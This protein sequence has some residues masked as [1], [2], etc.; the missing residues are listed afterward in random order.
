MSSN[1][2]R[3]PVPTCLNLLRPTA[4]GRA[5]VE[6]FIEV[7]FAQAWGARVTEFLPWLGALRDDAGVLVGA[8]GMRPAETGPLFLEQ[9]LDAPVEALLSE[10]V[11]E[12]VA[13]AGITEVGN[14]AAVIPGGAR[15]LITAM[16]GCLHA[17][18]SEWVV[19]TGGTELLNA[20][21][22]L[23]LYP[24]TLGP[25]DPARLAPSSADW[26][27]YYDQKPVVM[28]GRVGMAF[29]AMSQLFTAECALR[30]LWD[31][32]GRAGAEA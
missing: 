4:S 5:E 8:M 18:G 9:Y 19:F 29:D 24:I 28:A 16:T 3:A 7:C 6:R 22:R 10:R 1:R 31:A 23:G 25:A 21:H 14:L 2:R 27:R 26:G 13:R 30:A 12:S 17:A 11:G 15:W 20:F 32:A